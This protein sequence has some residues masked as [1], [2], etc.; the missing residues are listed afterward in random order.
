MHEAR[1]HRRMKIPLQVEIYHDSL[2]SLQVEAS[3]MSDGG[4]FLILD[5]CFQLNLGEQVT[6]RTLG[7]GADGTDSGPA[8]FMRVAR[9]TD[10]GMGLEMEQALDQS[11]FDP[12][13]ASQFSSPQQ[14]I[15]Q[16]LFIVNEQQQ[17]LVTM[18]GDHWRLPCRELAFGESW[19]EGIDRSV[20]Q[21]EGASPK[22][23]PDNFTSA[24]QCIPSSNESSPLIDML[25]PCRF[26]EPSPEEQNK[27]AHPFRWIEINEFTQLNCHLDPVAVDNILGQ[28]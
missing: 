21:L 13:K 27:L 9:K 10:E 22:L 2:G 15:L 25:I 8:L 5:E 23:G 7:L 4:V 26:H 18:Q 1:R 20:K 16:S 24:A 14:S 19:Q 11:N 28:V 6:V 12:D 17:V 3:D